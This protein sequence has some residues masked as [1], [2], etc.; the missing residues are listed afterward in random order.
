MNPKRRRVSH[1]FS[2]KFFVNYSLSFEDR[3][4]TSETNES[5]ENT[6][7][8]TAILIWCFT[9]CV[10]DIVNKAGMCGQVS[11][12]SVMSQAFCALLWERANWHGYT[13]RSSNSKQEKYVC[14]I[15]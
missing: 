15:K 1:S 14:H 10:V 4:Q 11:I 2:V 5:H 9:V 6:A 8:S 7:M 12:T 3:K 13:L